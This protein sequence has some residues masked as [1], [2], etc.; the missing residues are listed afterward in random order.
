MV[1]RM[2]L[3][4]AGEYLV[5]LV[6]REGKRETTQA[7]SLS[8]Y[9]SSTAV[10]QLF[11]PTALPGC[12]KHLLS[13]SHTDT[14][15]RI[16]RISAQVKINAPSNANCS[17]KVTQSSLPHPKAAPAPSDVPKRRANG[18]SSPHPKDSHP[19]PSHFLTATRFQLSDQGAT[20]WLR[21]Q[22]QSHA[23]N[24]LRMCRRY[25][26]NLLSLLQDP[27]S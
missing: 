6:G 5:C 7:D 3:H 2:Y 18:S 25:P 12:C 4:D 1:Q 9:S 20:S 15:V 17:P 22:N 19:F 21:D 14:H 11:V 24:P 27:A 23:Q 13:P 26:A 8:A 10:L 16:T